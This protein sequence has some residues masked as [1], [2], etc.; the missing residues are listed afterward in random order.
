MT[1]SRP[2]E[3]IVVP[4]AELPVQQQTELLAWIRQQEEQKRLLD[5]IHYYVLQFVD[6]TPTG[7][8]HEMHASKACELNAERIFAYMKSAR[9]REERWQRW[10]QRVKAEKKEAEAQFKW[11]KKQAADAAVCDLPLPDTEAAWALLEWRRA[12]PAEV[13]PLEPRVI[14]PPD[15]NFTDSDCLWA[16]VLNP[17][18]QI[19]TMPTTLRCNHD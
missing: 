10:E 1:L 16:R 9:E 6:G 8:V 17:S 18:G 7:D 13:Q 12:H 2:T 14:P 11:L 3:G 15:N 19:I 4:C 5:P